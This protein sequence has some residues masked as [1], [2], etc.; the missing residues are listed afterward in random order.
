MSETRRPVTFR[1]HLP[2]R[3]GDLLS[4]EV[5]VAALGRASVT[6]RYRAL[7]KGRLAF[8]VTGTTVCVDMRT[9]KPKPVP[10]RYRSLLARHLTGPRP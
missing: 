4:V 3:F 7:V 10:T 6:F 8:Q 1:C 9:F 5:A 2:V